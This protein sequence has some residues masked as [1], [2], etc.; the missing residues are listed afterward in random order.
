MLNK[1]LVHQTIG[2]ICILALITAAIAISREHDLSAGEWFSPYFAPIIVLITLSQ[3]GLAAIRWLLFTGQAV[4]FFD[5]IKAARFNALCYVA[6][7]LPLP[8]AIVGRAIF[9]QQ[10]TN[11]RFPTFTSI[12]YSSVNLAACLVLACL[13]SLVV[14]NGKYF[15]FCTSIFTLTLCSQLV[16]GKRLNISFYS[17]LKNLSFE[18]VNVLLQTAKL[19]A[20]LLSLNVNA[21]SAFTMSLLTSASGVVTAIASFA[22]GGGIGSQELAAYYSAR[23]LSMEQPEV[24]IV[25]LVIARLFTITL[26]LTIMLTRNIKPTSLMLDGE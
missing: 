16:I 2:N 10:Q 19:S 26:N 1:Q 7:L 17:T 6:N 22:P 13:F 25:A 11:K 12:W 8:G 23:V 18:I 3:M 24:I 4:T 20:V 5:L 9:L 15:E 14:L 21:V